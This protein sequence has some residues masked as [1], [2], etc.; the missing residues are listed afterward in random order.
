M[1]SIQRKCGLLSLAEAVSVSVFLPSAKVALNSLTISVD[2]FVKKANLPPLSL[3]CPDLSREFLSQFSGQVFSL[4]QQLALDLG[5]TKLDLTVEALDHADILGDNFGGQGQ[6]GSGLLQ[7][8]LLH[9][10]S[11]FW[12]K[13]SS[14][15]VKITFTGGGD[16]DSSASASGAMNETLFKSDFNFEQ[17]GIGGLDEQFKKLFRTAF[18]SRIFP[19]LVKQL[20]INHVRGILLYG[21]PGCGKTLIARQIGKVLN[22]R[23]PKTIAGPEVLDK[24]V[25]GSEQKIR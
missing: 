7:G 20:G 18:A 5:G 25:G 2:L 4:R 3:D 19:G 22:A 17:L 16:S 1:N 24:F 11:V 13:S 8:Q 10:T 23:E 6:G 15:V 9:A 14:S 12:K 21:P